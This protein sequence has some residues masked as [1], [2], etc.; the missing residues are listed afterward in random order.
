MNAILA[1][2]ALAVTIGA[3]VAVSARETRA[4]LVGL[5]VVLGAAPFLNE[6]EPALST[7]AARVV[8]AALAAW[9]LRAATAAAGP[10]A[11]RPGPVAAAGDG[12]ARGGSRLGWPA[13]TLFATAAWVVGAAVAW[14]LRLV[15]PTGSDLPPDGLLGF[16]GPSVFAAAA[17]CA[18]IVLGVVPTFWSRHPVRTTI[19][20]LVLA[21]GVLLARVGI[22]GDPGDLEQ[23]ASVALLITIAAAG[24]VLANA[25][26]GR[27][28][29]IAET[30]ADPSESAPR[31]PRVTMAALVR[32][33]RRPG[34]P[35]VPVPDS[36]IEGPRG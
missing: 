14:N 16:L 22:A 20:A 30:P 8:G 25:G 28:D 9:L 2:V 7:L 4:A 26:A 27:T 35:T 32:G 36:T 12:A 1:G 17:G 5:A 29:P 13:E 23:L 34:L 33:P 10:P 19:G 15:A 6:A 24:A 31:R 21:Q 11:A 3:V 18:A